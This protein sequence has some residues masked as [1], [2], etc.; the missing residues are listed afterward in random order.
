[1]GHFLVCKVIQTGAFQTIDLIQK[2]GEANKLKIM[3]TQMNKTKPETSLDFFFLV[4]GRLKCQRCGDLTFGL[5]NAKSQGVHEGTS[6]DLIQ[7][8]AWT[9][10]FCLCEHNS[11]Q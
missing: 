10:W 6:S 8:S 3:S 1:M 9:T 5:V 2:N 7:M 11:Q 4:G